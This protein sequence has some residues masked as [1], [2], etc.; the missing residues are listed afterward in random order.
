MRANERHSSRPL[1]KQELQDAAIALS[2]ANLSLSD[3]WQKISYGIQLLMPVWTWRDI[4]A[5]SVNLG[6]L[7]LVFWL[8][9]CSSRRW[10]GRELQLHSLLVLVPIITLANLARRS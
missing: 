5:M 10:R 2:L 4:A 1:L 6:W 3:A 9:I 8:L 7:T